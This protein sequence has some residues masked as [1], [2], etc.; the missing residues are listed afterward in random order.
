M[1]DAGKYAELE[2][3]AQARLKT[4]NADAE[5]SAALSLA[6]TLVDTVDAKR[7]EAGA[8]QA[9]LCTEQH[10]NVAVCHLA[11]AQNLSMQ[12]INMGMVKAMRSVG[13]LKP[14]LPRATRRRLKRPTSASLPTSGPIRP[15]SK[16]HARV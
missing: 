15:M 16:T 12:M 13:T 7:L 9:R 11:A 6:L 3:L 2:Q 10:P 1:Q 5:A 4:N 14:Y 8:N